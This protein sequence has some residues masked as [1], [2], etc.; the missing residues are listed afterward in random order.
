MRLS[1]PLLS[2]PEPVFQV[3]F[4]KPLPRGG[5]HSDGW[6]SLEC[7]FWFTPGIAPAP[8]LCSTCC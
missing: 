1:N 8:L 4:G 6:G 3:H 5:V 2:W 7:Y